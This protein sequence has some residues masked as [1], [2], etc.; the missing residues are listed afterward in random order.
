VL[1]WIFARPLVGIFDSNPEVIATASA[2]LLIVPFSLGGFGVMLVAVAAFNALGRPLPAT[3][4]TFIKLFLAY[5]PLAWMLS[6][7]AGIDGI[8]WANAIVHL[9]FGVAGFIWF[10][11]VLDG[12][13]CEPVAEPAE[14]TP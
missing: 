2:Y 6:A 11:R 9:A 5:I 3:V 4:L 1:F 14:S 8:F 12:L 10:R 13:D 7:A